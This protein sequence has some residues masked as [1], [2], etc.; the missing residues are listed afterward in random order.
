[1]NTLYPERSNTLGGLVLQLLDEINAEA[2]WVD[3]RNNRRYSLYE[4]RATEF[5]YQNVHKR[6]TQK[7][8]ARHL[9]ITPEYFSAVFKKSRGMTPMQFVNRVKLSSIRMAMAKDNLKLCEAA[10]KFG[11]SDPNYVSKLFKKYYGINITSSIP[12]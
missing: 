3:I 7:D 4:H 2:F 6:I 1:M 12:K 9:G 11:Y 5:I 8:I 10:E